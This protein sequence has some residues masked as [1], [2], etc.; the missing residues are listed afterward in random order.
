MLLKDAILSCENYEDQEETLYSV[1]AKRINGK[2]QPDSEALILELTIEEME[3]Q[4]A[5][6]AEEKCPGY[7]YFLEMFILKDFYTDLSNLEEYR[8]DAKKVERIIYFAEFDA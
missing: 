7:D 4:P 3:I 6:I 1:F 5:K 8:S 2:F